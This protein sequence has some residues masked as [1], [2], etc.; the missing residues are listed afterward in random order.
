MK[1][2]GTTI[3]S[4]K[5]GGRGDKGDCKCEKKCVQ[6]PGFLQVRHA[7]QESLLNFHSGSECRKFVLSLCSAY[8]VVKSQCHCL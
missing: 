4:C 7:R 6:K 3:F 2:D 8:T 1:V 5:I